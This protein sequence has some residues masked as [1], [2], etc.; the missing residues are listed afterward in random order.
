[1][2]IPEASAQ[3][4]MGYRGPRGQGSMRKGHRDSGC[5]KPYSRGYSSS[6]AMLSPAGNFYIY[7]SYPVGDGG[8]GTRACSDK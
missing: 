8:R 4:S 2:L 3:F 6:K 7:C 5:F 1:M